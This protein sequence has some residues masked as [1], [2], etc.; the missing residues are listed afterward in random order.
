MDSYDTQ[1]EKKVHVGV[2]GNVKKKV[3]KKRA[4]RA[5]WREEKERQRIKPAGSCPPPSLPPSP[6]PM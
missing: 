5:N 4:A 1:Y 3:D 2:Q 6:R